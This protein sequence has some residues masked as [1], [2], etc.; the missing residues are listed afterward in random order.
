MKDEQHV[1]P[2]DFYFLGSGPMSDF[3]LGAIAGAQWM[4]TDCPRERTKAP[5]HRRCVLPP[6]RV[7]P[8]Q[9]L[10]WPS[11]LATAL[12][13]NPASGSRVFR[14]ADLGAPGPRSPF[15]SPPYWSEASQRYVLLTTPLLS[16]SG[17]FFHPLQSPSF[18]PITFKPS[19]RT[20]FFPLNLHSANWLACPEHPENSENLNE[21][22]M[23]RRS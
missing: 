14:K 22:K 5:A 16:I 9:A 7:R 12:S 6:R 10:C 17:L 2:I 3:S 23:L 21:V 15:Q 18:F 20:H 13:G 4:A 1:S 19:H 8:S 11:P